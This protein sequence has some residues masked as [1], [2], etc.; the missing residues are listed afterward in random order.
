V[1]GLAKAKKTK[2]TPDDELQD[3]IRRGGKSQ[4]YKLRW[5]A[6]RMPVVA[7]PKEHVRFKTKFFWTAFVLLVYFAMTNVF[8]F[9]LDPSGTQIDLFEQFRAILGG[10]QGSIM[11]L[12]IG[13]I[14]TG[15]I[16]MQLFTGA[17]IF[18]L[19]LTNADDK[20]VYQGVQK[21]V[22]VI[23][24]IVESWAQVQGFLTPSP[25]LASSLNGSNPW[26]TGQQ[27]AK[28]I[29]ILQLCV[30]S[31]L[32]FLLDE[33]VS[34]WGIG[35]GISLFI[36]AGVA[37]QIVTGAVNWAPTDPALP[38]SWGDATTP[39]NLPAGTIPK[40]WYAM[41]HSS[42]QALSQGNYEQIFLQ[43][44]NSIV[45]L[46]GTAVVF[47]IVAYA[48]TTR[49][50]LP[51]AHTK[52][53]GARGKYP[54]R[55]IYASNIPVILMAALLANINMMAVLFWSGPLSGV[56]GLGGNSA[57]GVFDA[58]GEISNSPTTPVGGFAWYVSMPAGLQ[59]W[60]LPLLNYQQYGGYTYG[61][62]NFKVLLHVLTYLGFMIFGSILFAK[63]WIETTNMGPEAV[64]KQIQK[65]G[66]QIPGFRRDPKVLRRV[67]D[68]YI[69]A[70]TVMSGAFVG[71]LAGVA[72]MIGT[73]GQ[74]S[75]T[76]VLLMVGIIIRMSEQIVK[77][78]EIDRQPI[79]AR[80]FGFET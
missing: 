22:V 18:K 74:S 2:L 6:R 43:P 49:L 52:V 54:I 29:I 26:L 73:T 33:L 50:E 55:L 17:K 61:H 13:P 36:A 4:L 24:I 76:G 57:L 15:S 23:M 72:D 42:S 35:S 37:Q 67:L 70:V 64:A 75:G 45:A 5:L 47:I 32:V 56:W 51:L 63:F 65:S 21:I 27:L 59:D 12:G 41:T 19:D 40:V 16:I 9:G 46:M 78:R 7:K 44:P 79:L 48:E 66:M 34:K 10:A 28:G 25:V 20:S 53:R 1:N 80:L 8:L 71:A 11:H 3:Q 77:E 30:G 60:L 14:V 58:T 39:A 38:I 68:Q 69:P 62:D 31:Y